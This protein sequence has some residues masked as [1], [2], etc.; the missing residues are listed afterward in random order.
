M[1]TSVAALLQA[2]PDVIFA[3]DHHGVIT[4]AN[5]PAAALVGL[6]PSEVIGRHLERDFPHTLSAEWPQVSQRARA[7]TR[8]VEY[9]A[10]NANVGRWLHGQVLLVPDGLLVQV[11]DVTGLH[12]AE[13]LHQ[14]TAALGTAQTEQDVVGVV[15]EQAIPAL[16]AHRGAMLAL[17][18]DRKALELRR[19]EKYSPEE[20]ERFRWFALTE[21]LPACRAARDGVPVFVSAPDAA[22][23]YS[24]W[25]AVRSVSTQS[26][27]ALPLSFAG[28]V[29]AVLVLSFDLPRRFDEAERQFLITLTGVGAQALERARLYDTEARGRLRAT[30]L[31]EAGTLLATS[32]KVEDALNRL[33]GL[34]LAHVADWAA[35]YLPDDD[36][37]VGPV[38]VAHRDPDMIELLRTFVAQNPADPE[39]PG[40]TAWVMRTGES[41][42]VPTVPPGVIDAIEDPERRAAIVRMGLHSL[43]HVPLTVDGR[44]VGVLGLASSSTAQTYGPEDLRLAEALA[45]RAALALE[46]A[47]LFETSQHNEQ[48]YR[49]LV[50]ATRQIVWTNTPDGRMLG[51]QPG[52]AALT[53][54][55]ENE[56]RG[57]GWADALH[58]EDRARSVVTWQEAVKKSAPCT[59]EHRVRVADGTYRH[60][61]VRA[62]PVLNPNGMIREWVG[63]HTNITAQ[64]EAEA[65]LERRVAERTEAL[66][67]S[68]AELERYA[69][70]ASHDLQEPL[71]TI[72]SLTGLLE[73]RYAHVFDERGRTLL[74]L[75]VGGTTRMKMLLDDLLLYS[76]MGA[77][78]LTL[79]PVKTTATMEEILMR[80]DEQ[81][82]DSRGR[83]DYA[84]LPVVCGNAFQ[85]TQL[86][87]NL[88]GNA[89][90]FRKPDVAPEVQ[91]SAV[92]TGAL[93]QFSVRDNGIGIDPAY[94][95]RIFV[96]FQRL[97]GREQYAGTGLGLAICQKVVERHGGRIWVESAP[98]V[99]SAFH[100]TLKALEACEP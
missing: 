58:P 78:Q 93:W 5:P 79:E 6:T 32:L 20:R 47:T 80:L 45:A 33:T 4:Y 26:I 69:Y 60:F 35:V 43:I 53:G 2:T 89:L 48:R 63:V 25:D 84:D 17:S 28:G 66:A 44:T 38:A 54:Q 37:V 72:A 36:G 67:R 39:S 86:F 11:R 65:E 73:R 51:E 31:A 98:G 14:V 40:S 55:G 74:S 61:D 88:I 96:M 18:E 23:E 8:P 27:A 71:R 57:Y 68:N 24:G 77:E 9:I 99:G 10:F 3:L 22:R 16:G 29:Q 49:S 70:V 1:P 7:S 41:F 50:D 100:F 90:K 21:D 56:Y 95:D 82:V 13:Q 94:F 87:Q 62:V 34:A 76:R 81:L 92:R 19:E 59:M 97:H 83:V 52:W 75:I 15:L 64:V 46:N 91:I 85:L 30:V 12:R 42:L